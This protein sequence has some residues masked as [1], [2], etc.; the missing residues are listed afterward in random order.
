M[1]AAVSELEDG[2][3]EEEEEEEAATAPSGLKKEKKK[4]I[5]C[6]FC[7]LTQ[8]RLRE[9]T[10]FLFPSSSCVS[11]S[12]RLRPP[13]TSGRGSGSGCLA[14]SPEE[15]KSS[16]DC[17]SFP[18]QLSGHKTNEFSNTKYNALIINY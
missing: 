18:N 8:Q 4:F 2:E 17:S 5:K 12:C 10:Y 7:I 6:F 1:T 15:T 13:P 9:Q 16:P 14:V 11:V 3:E